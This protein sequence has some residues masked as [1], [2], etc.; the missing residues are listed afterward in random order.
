MIEDQNELREFCARCFADD[1][2]GSWG[3]GTSGTGFCTNCCS[4]ATIRIPAWAVASIR[5]QA[6]WVGKRYYS[7]AE[8]REAYEERKVLLALVPEFPGRSFEQRDDGP[9]Q[10]NVWQKLPGGGS[11]MTI[12]RAETGEAAMRA[13][14]LRYVT[15][16]QLVGATTGV[17]SDG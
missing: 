14:H 5:E 17:R 12:V 16:E 8:D 1:K 9:D 7:H 13:C 2:G 10:W 15:S 4:R 3:S 6:S 11:V